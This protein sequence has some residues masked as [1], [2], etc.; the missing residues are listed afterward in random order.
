MP[1]ILPFF[2]SS[3]I[4]AKA[5]AFC[6]T[7]KLALNS[8]ELSSL[9]HATQMFHHQYRCYCDYWEHILRR[10]SAE[11][12]RIALWGADAKGVMFLNT[13]RHL[14]LPSNIVD[15]NPHKWG[16]LRSWHRA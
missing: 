6:E 10:F 15:V 7:R 3:D 11:G 5:L 9:R 2:E 16:T 4:L 12:K 13:F 1:A 14:E 8:R